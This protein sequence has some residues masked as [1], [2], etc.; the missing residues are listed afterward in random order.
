MVIIFKLNENMPSANFIST[1][2]IA[3]RSPVFGDNSKQEGVY[4]ET[5]IKITASRRPS[6]LSLEFR[7]Y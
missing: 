2:S 3:L 1:E 6:F 5:Q 7:R 4:Q